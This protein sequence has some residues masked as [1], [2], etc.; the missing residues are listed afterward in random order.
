MITDIVEQFVKITC[1]LFATDLYMPGTVKNTQS[2]PCLTGH[3]KLAFQIQICTF[4]NSKLLQFLLSLH[5]ICVSV[6]W[7][8]YRC[9]YMYL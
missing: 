5:K 7:L 9:V 4:D 8:I 1:V 2:V 3:P 6:N